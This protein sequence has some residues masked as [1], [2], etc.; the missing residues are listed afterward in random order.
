MEDC[1]MRKAILA[2]LFFQ[3]ACLLAGD[4]QHAPLPDK[5]VSA[6]TVFLMNES[7]QPKLGDAVYKQIKTWNQW[8]VV[9]DR[10]AAD[11]VLTTSAKGAFGQGYYLNVTDA[12]TGELLW[13]RKATMQGK[14]WR[15]WNAI[16]KD[17]TAELRT[18]MK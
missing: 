18:R 4:D 2:L 3:A 15:T 6:K 10:T 9:T 17:L 5:I 14:L 8:Q 16:A 1:Q 7:G 11:L 13:T 12:K